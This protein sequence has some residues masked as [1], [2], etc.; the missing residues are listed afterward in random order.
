M[1]H[2]ISSSNNDH[3]CARSFSIF[4]SYYFLIPSKLKLLFKGFKLVRVLELGCGGKIPFTSILTLGNLQTIDLGHWRR[5]FPI[6]FPAG[7]WKLDHLRHLYGQ[8]PIMLRGHCSGSNEVMLNLQTIFP[9]ALDRQT[10]SLIK[11]G[12]VVKEPK[13]MVAAAATTEEK[14]NEN[15]SSE[16]SLEDD[17]SWRGK[18]GEDRVRV[19]VFEEHDWV[20]VGTYDGFSG[21]DVL[22]YLL[23]NLH[24]AVHKELKGLLWDDGS[25]PENSMIKEDRL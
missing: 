15:L 7:I 12:V 21:P 10:T 20:F 8:A 13:W 11:K 2:Y 6:S 1:A 23:S 16:G 24:T 18:V 22:D 19:V 4:G 9:I 5:N 3:S 14:H 17:D 25:A